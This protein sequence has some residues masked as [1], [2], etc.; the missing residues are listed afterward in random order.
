LDALVPIELD[1]MVAMHYNHWSG[2]HEP[3]FAKH[4]HTWGEAGTALDAESEEEEEA[5]STSSSESESESS[6]SDT[7]SDDPDKDPK[8]D[9]KP[10]DKGKKDAVP[11]ESQET[12]KT[13]SGRQVRVP[14]QFREPFQMYEMNAAN[15]SLDISSEARDV[16]QMRE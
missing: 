12:V 2:G 3:P 16:K 10:K 6:E 8:E 14:K 13:R 7:D 1:G 15:F 9:P 4:L 5:S 11:S